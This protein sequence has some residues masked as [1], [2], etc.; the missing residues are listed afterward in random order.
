VARLEAH[1]WRIVDGSETA[2]DPEAFRRYVQGS[3]AELSVAKGVFVRTEGGWFS[4]RTTRYLASGKPAVVQDTGFTRSIPAGEGLFTFRSLDDVVEAVSRI[5]AD[6]ERHSHAARA[7]AE[8]HFDS[9]VV[10]T[11][12]LDAA[13]VG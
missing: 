11:R 13:G 2:G 4:D 1:G 10:L 7:L 12:F 5:G 9:D 3:G 8:R 6:Y